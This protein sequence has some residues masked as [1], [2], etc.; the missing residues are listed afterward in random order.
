MCL[1]DKSSTKI[2]NKKYLGSFKIET[3]VDLY[4]GPSLPIKKI[5]NE[6][7]INKK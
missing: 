6:N 7:K 4:G 2:K 1:N 5:N 3:I